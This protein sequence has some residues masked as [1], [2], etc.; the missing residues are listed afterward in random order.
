MSDQEQAT[1]RH[2]QYPDVYLRKSATHMAIWSTAMIDLVDALS[3]YLDAGWVLHSWHP[4]H[5]SR[6]GIA[7]VGWTAILQRQ[8]AVAG[9]LRKLIG[10]TTPVERK[11]GRPKG[12]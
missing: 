2:P 9:A 1:E 11:V 12:T 5:Q 4:G 7:P 10:T 3:I 6:G 8:E